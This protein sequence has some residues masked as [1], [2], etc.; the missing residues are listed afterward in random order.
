M[1]KALVYDGRNLIL[2]LLTQAFTSRLF[3]SLYIRTMTD[4]RGESRASGRSQYS[5]SV[6]LNQDIGD[7]STIEQ[8]LGGHSR[9]TNSKAK[10]TRFDL[11]PESEPA[12]EPH[13][14]QQRQTYTNM[15]LQAKL[16]DRLYDKPEHSGVM[17]YVRMLSMRKRPISV[18]RFKFFFHQH[19]T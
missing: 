16:R 18:V 13:I 14:E 11:S 7:L 17:N 8:D 19:C 10:S 4:P 1:T 9:L 12:L 2:R 15:S 5:E 6:V 3:F